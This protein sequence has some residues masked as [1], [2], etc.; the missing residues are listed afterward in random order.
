MIYVYV[1]KTKC[2]QWVWHCCKIE[3]RNYHGNDSSFIL[4]M[5]WWIG[6][7]LLSN[8]EYSPSWVVSSLPSVLRVFSLGKF[9]NVISTSV[10]LATSQNT[11]V[12]FTLVSCGYTDCDR[13]CKT[14]QWRHNGRDSVSNHQ[15]HHCLLKHLFRRRS[16]KTSM[17]RVTGLCAGNSPGTSE[18][19]AQ[20]ASNAENVFIRWRH[21]GICKS[22][23]ARIFLLT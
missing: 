11:F 6:I 10:Y 14:L 13:I 12:V 17:L 16:K 1:I 5:S 8:W 21:H 19:P 20:M 15:P 23:T 22:W 7:V 3:F 4:A 18:F 9:C 2:L